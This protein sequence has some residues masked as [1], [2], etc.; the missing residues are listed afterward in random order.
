MLDDTTV[1]TKALGEIWGAA[2]G[3]IADLEHVTM[4]GHRP[5]ISLAISSGYRSGGERRRSCVGGCST[6]AGTDGPLAARYGV[7]APRRGG[8]PQ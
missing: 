4:R 5:S 3:D 1:A 6:M 7:D 8:L 2:S